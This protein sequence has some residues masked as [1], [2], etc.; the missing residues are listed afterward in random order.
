M[1]P[2]SKA[3]LEQL[4]RLYPTTPQ[5]ELARILGRP[6]GSVR[7]RA[8]RWRLR[9]KRDGYRQWTPSQVALVRKLY[10]DI[11]TAELAERV[12]RSLRSV[13]NAAKE[14]G[15]RKSAAYMAS[16]AASRLR[17]GNNV[18]AAFRYK[19]GHV[20]ANKGLRRPGWAPGRMAETQFKKGSRAGVAQAKWKPV[21]TIMLRDGYPIMKVKDEPQDI[22]GI[23]ANSTNWMYVHKMVWEQAHGPIPEGHRIWWKDRDHLNCSL[24]NLELLSD[25]QHMART[26]IHNLPKPLKLAIYAL[27]ALNRQI[28]RKRAKKQA[29]GSSQPPVRDDRTA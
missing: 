6:L 23:G 24:E 19:P 11:P 5:K 10:A 22:A 13:Y 21:G 26:T 28:R 15:L 12:G 29:G 14:L 7:T 16:P 27:G 9:R 8:R 3:E 20:P 1:K 4:R 25:K 2:W 17:R 18:G